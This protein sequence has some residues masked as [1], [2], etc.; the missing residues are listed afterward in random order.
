MLRQDPVDCL[1]SFICSSNNHISRIHGMVER[2]AAAYGTPLRP[3]AECAGADAPAAAAAC[4]AALPAAPEAQ[5]QPQS[6]VIKGSGEDTVAGSGGGGGSGRS[7]ASGG[8]AG[9]AF[10]AFPTIEQLAA[11]TE[12]DL[13]AAGFGCVIRT[14][15]P[16]ASPRGQGGGGNGM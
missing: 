7:S 12:A 5:P 4:A 2:L 15:P 9:L 10:Y 11:A 6:P 13:R 1:F 14:P 3:A 16:V 8:S